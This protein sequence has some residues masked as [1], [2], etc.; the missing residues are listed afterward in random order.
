MVR[1][2]QRVTDKYRIGLIGVER[3]VCLKGQIIIAQHRT[4]RECEWLRKVCELR[5]SNQRDTP[6]FKNEKKPD[7]LDYRAFAEI[8][9]AALAV[10]VG[11][12][13]Q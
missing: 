3:A 13:Q 12:L 8:E 10:F 1:G 6:A 7:S 4:T 9:I 2:V 11:S 5:F